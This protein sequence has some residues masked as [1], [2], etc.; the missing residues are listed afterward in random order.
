MNAAMTVNTREYAIWCCAKCAKT[1]QIPDVTTYTVSRECRHWNADHSVDI[2]MMTPVNE[3]AV[4][5]DRWE[6]AADEAHR[7]QV[8]RERALTEE[9]RDWRFGFA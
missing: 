6:K 9:R 7:N 8:M 3:R 5:F 1:V 2:W 4:A